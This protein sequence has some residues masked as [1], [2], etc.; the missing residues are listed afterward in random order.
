[1]SEILENWRR[2]LGFPGVLVI[3]GHTHIQQYLPDKHFRTPEEAAEEAVAEM[4]ANGVDA[5]CVLSGGY[6][7]NGADYRQGNDFLLATCRR[8]PDRLIPFILLNPADRKPNVLAE[9]E[10]MWGEGVHAIKLINS[11]EG[12][13]GDGPTLMAVYEF[14]QEHNMLVLNHHWS[15]AELRRISAAFPELIMIRAHGGASALSAELANVYDNIWALWPLGVIESGCKEH[16][17]E[18]ILFGSDA[19]WNDVSVGLGLVLYADIP[20]EHKRL[21]LGLNM[22]RLL[23]RVGALPKGLAQA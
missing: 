19:G 8:A 17:P 11:Y 21:I 15:E 20:D 10:R 14:A 16:R 3:D 13:P 22:A 2:G 12:Y 1:M 6:M 23:D 18:K 7:E 9:L 4:D 5:D